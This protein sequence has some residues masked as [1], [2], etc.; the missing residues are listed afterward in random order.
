MMAIK[1]T[2]HK[3]FTYKNDKSSTS[4]YDDKRYILLDGI[5]TFPY[6]HKNIP[7]NE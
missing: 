4:C 2:K 3:L 5:N 1:S 6:G 7:K